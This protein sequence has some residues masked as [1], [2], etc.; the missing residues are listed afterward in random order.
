MTR[1]CDIRSNG[2]YALRC[3]LRHFSVGHPLRSLVD[4]GCHQDVGQNAPWRE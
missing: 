2:N 1:S 3:I 4:P